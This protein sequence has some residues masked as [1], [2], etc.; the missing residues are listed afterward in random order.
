MMLGSLLGDGVAEAAEPLDQALLGA[1]TQAALEIGFAEIVV[2][3]VITQDVIGGDQQAMADGHGGLLRPA[4]G[5]QATV[6]GSGVGVFGVTG[7]LSGLDKR[8]A[9]PGAALA[10]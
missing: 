8:A 6:L 9:Q 1:L 5:G 10:G 4:A 3:G 2:G 7:G